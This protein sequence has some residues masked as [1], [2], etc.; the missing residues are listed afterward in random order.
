MQQSLHAAEHSAVLLAQAN[1]TSKETPAV[2]ILRK[3][4]DPAIRSRSTSGAS[5]KMTFTKADLV[6]QV[7]N[8]IREVEEVL[9]PPKRRSTFKSA[10]QKYVKREK[11]CTMWSVVDLL[12]GERKTRYAMVI[13]NQPITRIDIFKKAWRACE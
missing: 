2:Q 8:A 4:G 10:A 3:S 5:K 11:D 13:L 1:K 7:A 12:A 6:A 9:P